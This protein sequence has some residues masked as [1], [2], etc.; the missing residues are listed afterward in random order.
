MILISPMRKSSV[1][2]SSHQQSNN[3]ARVQQQQQPTRRSPSASRSRSRSVTPARSEDGGEYVP[4]TEESAA[5]YPKFKK[6]AGKRRQADADESQPRRAKK[7]RVRRERESGDEG[8]EEEEAPVVYDE[9][10]CG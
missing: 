5:K 9:A 4:A 10:T 8:V 1:S 6:T 7:K 3:Q 2:L